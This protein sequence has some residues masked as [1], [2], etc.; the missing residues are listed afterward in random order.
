MGQYRILEPLSYQDGDK[1]IFVNK[2][3]PDAVTLSDAV[4]KE[5]GDKVKRV[6]APTSSAKEPASEDA[7]KT[8]SKE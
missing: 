5:L 2:P 6:D 8:R 7:P 1:T 4:A 3:K